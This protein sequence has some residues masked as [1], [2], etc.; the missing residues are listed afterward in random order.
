MIILISNLSEIFHKLPLKN[1]KKIALISNAKDKNKNRL[2]SIKKYKNFFINNNYDVDI[3]DLKNFK[4]DKLYKKLL[5]YDIIFVMGG[6]CFYLLDLIRKSGFDKILDSLLKEGII[7]IG[8]SAGACI[9]GSSIEP[10]KPMHEPTNTNLK[11]FEG[12]GYLD[13]VFVPHYKNPKYNKALEQIEQK[14]NNSF[15]LKKFKDSQGLIINKKSI[16]TI[17]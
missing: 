5:R 8:Q 10:I 9:M 15:N 7:Y 2:L 13:Y 16:I 4:R 3:V 1:L 11:N 12:L 14:Y 6:N 17:G